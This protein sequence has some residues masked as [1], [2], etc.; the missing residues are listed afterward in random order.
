VTS[1]EQ[2]NYLP[3]LAARIRAEHR[4]TADALKS[5]AEHGIA[6]S[7]LLIEAKAKVPHGQWLP[8]LKEHCVI[9]ERTAQIY[10]RL[11]KNRKEVEEQ[12][13]MTSSDLTVTEATALLMLSSDTR[14]LLQFFQNTAGLSS[15]EIVQAALD[16][17]VAF[18]GV[19]DGGYRVFAHCTP[20]GERDW[21]L[22]MLF[23]CLEHGWYADAAAQ[24]TEYLSQKQFIDPDE[25]LGEEGN[26]F[27][28]SCGGYDNPEMG[29]GVLRNWAA[30][31]E[32][33]RGRTQAEISAEIEVIAKERG[34]A[35]PPPPPGTSKPR[36]RGRAKRFAPATHAV[37]Q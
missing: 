8:W 26:R 35:P 12:I 9:S 36:K 7:E 2:S 28:R 11:A 30:F 22:F 15:E 24:H 29:A 20:E 18:V 16:Q 33:Y 34:P 23:L 14:L 10:M 6:A 1:I 19:N 5:S 21:H 13:R 32:H 27:R 31:K 17:R 3:E 25:W 4:A 37:F